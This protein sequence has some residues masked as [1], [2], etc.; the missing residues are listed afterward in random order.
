MSIRIGIKI[1]GFFPNAAIFVIKG[2]ST[3]DFTNVIL[4]VDK[5][6]VALNGTGNT[7]LIDLAKKIV[8]EAR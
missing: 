4:A 8:C 2:V 5:L 7:N 1:G 3:E 6:R